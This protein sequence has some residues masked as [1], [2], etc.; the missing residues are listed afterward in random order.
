MSCK[1]VGAQHAAPFCT[2]RPYWIEAA[3]C[4]VE[5]VRVFWQRQIP[6]EYGLEFVDRN[7]LENNRVRPA[8]DRC[9]AVLISHPSRTDDDRHVSCRSTS[10]QTGSRLETIH[11]GHTEVHKYNVWFVS[12]GLLHSNFPVVCLDD[13]ATQMANDHC[14]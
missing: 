8:F 4:S 12:E 3:E 7:R 14:E 9:V 11:G 5:L 10:P 2:A 6:K 13:F 1:T